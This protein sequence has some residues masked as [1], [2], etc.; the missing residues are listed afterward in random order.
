[1]GYLEL[2]QQSQARLIETEKTAERTDQSAISQGTPLK[3][4][5]ARQ[6]AWST[7]LNLSRSLSFS[8]FVVQQTWRSPGVSPHRLRAYRVQ[9]G[10]SF[11]VASCSCPS[12]STFYNLREIEQPKKLSTLLRGKLDVSWVGSP[13]PTAPG[14]QSAHARAQTGCP[15]GWPHRPLAPR[16][17]YCSPSSCLAC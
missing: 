16:S 1:M 3:Q 4:R 17:A 9:R 11:R 10:E 7:S 6:R 14:P 13:M 12:A 5:G 15:A 2:Q 8:R